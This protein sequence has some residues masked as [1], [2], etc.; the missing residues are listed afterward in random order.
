MVVP[1]SAKTACKVIK[2][3]GGAPIWLG[4]EG[5]DRMIN[6]LEKRLFGEPIPADIQTFTGTIP[7]EA[8]LE[9]TAQLVEDVK[10]IASR[11]PG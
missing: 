5:L 9:S 11:L 3:V 1:D 6:G 4:S 2:S 7:K 8:D 10:N